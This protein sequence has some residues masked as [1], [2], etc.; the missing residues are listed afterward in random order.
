MLLLGCSA[1]LDTFGELKENSQLASVRAI[2]PKPK[3]INAGIVFLDESSYLCMPTSHFGIEESD[4]ILSVQTSCDCT[5]ASIV[6][7]KESKTKISRSLR[8]D[9]KPES[10]PATSNVSPVNLEIKITLKHSEASTTEVAINLLHTTRVH[11]T[12]DR[13]DRT[14]VREAH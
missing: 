6:L 1:K 12:V 2:S 7:Y 8:I 11:Y 14:E 4:D 3:V 13:Q 10:S 9:F 5:V